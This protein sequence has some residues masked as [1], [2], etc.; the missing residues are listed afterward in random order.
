MH[1]VNKMKIWRQDQGLTI[2]E[3]AEKLEVSAEYLGAVLSHKRPL[4][5]GI[6][7]R[8]IAMLAEDSPS[9]RS[10]VPL[11]IRFTAEEWAEMKEKLPP[12][13]DLEVFL[14]RYVL[15][16]MINEARA[17]VAAALENEGAPLPDFMKRSSG[18]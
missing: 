17:S 18:M 13:V 6:R 16:D 3:F 4:T 10:V 8:F 14:R 7:A 5:K 1:T 2:S 9:F 15:G 11:V 12:G